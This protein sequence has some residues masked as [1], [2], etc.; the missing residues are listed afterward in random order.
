MCIRDSCNP[1]HFE[2]GRVG[3]V[4]LVVFDWIQMRFLICCIADFPVY[5]DL[6]GKVQCIIYFVNNVCV[7]CIFFK[8]NY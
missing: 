7:L 1:V 5:M 8:S 6:S 3:E 2:G 4:G